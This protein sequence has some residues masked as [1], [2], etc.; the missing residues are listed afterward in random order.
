MSVDAQRLM[1]TVSYLHMIWSGPLQIIVSLV[2]L[3][4]YIGASVLAGVGVMILTIPRTLF[5]VTRTEVS[6]KRHVTPYW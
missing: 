6:E 1:D 4:Q 2:L 5:A 3:W